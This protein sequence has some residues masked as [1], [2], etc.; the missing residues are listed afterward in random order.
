MTSS[1]GNI[2]RITGP[3]CA[4]LTRHR[5][6]PRTKAS[7]VELW[8]FLWSVPWIN[9]WVNYRKAGDLRCHHAHYDVIVMSWFHLWVPHLQMSGSGMAKRQSV[10]K[11]KSHQGDS[12]GIH[13]RRWRQASMP[14]VNTKAVILMIFQFMW[15]HFV[16]INDV[17]LVTCIIRYVSSYCK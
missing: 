11:R 8:I 12:P 6:I 5:W 15:R 14:Q 2:F 4:E 3:L 10:L 9:G 16:S 17:C 13:W 1:N 7:D